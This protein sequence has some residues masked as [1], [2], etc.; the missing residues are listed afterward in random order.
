MCSVLGVI[1]G[2]LA[3]NGSVARQAKDTQWSG[4]VQGTLFFALPSN[5]EGLLKIAKVARHFVRPVTLDQIV[6]AKIASTAWAR[7]VHRNP[8]RDARETAHFG[9]SWAQTSVVDFLNANA[10]QE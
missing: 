4:G 6:W 5:V 7:V 10:T 9:A 3:T 2:A 1:Q 8:L